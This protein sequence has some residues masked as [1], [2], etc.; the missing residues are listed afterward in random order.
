[1]NASSSPTFYDDISCLG[2]LDWRI[3]REEYWNRA[4]EQEHRHAKL[5][6][7]AE[8]QI[9]VTVP[10][11]DILEIVVYEPTGRQWMEEQVAS[12]NLEIKV[13]M[14]RKLYY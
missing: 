8:A 6:R 1:M 9:P 14:D 11:K 3:L 2:L 7:Q 12:R 4:D 5:H 13:R 10:V